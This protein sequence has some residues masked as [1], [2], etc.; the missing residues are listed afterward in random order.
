VENIQNHGNDK[1][2]VKKRTK[3]KDQLKTSINRDHKK[4]NTKQKKP[5]RQHRERKRTT[6]HTLNVKRLTTILV[7]II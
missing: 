1:R 2:P 7:T 3:I 6:I 4:A 5:P